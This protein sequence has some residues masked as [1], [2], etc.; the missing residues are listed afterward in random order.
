LLQ[1]A[2]DGVEGW[3]PTSYLRELSTSGDPD[4]PGDDVRCCVSVTKRLVLACLFTRTH[5][6]TRNRLPFTLHLPHAHG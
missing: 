3:A 6:H 2:K 1:V 4:V 5:T